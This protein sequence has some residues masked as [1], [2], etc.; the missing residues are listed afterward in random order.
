MTPSAHEWHGLRVLKINS[1]EV[2]E[3]PA[4]L[5]GD[6]WAQE[7]ELVIVPVQRLDPAFF[8][9]SSGLAGDLLQ[10]FVNYGIRLVILG[11]LSAYTASSAALRA[12]VAESNRGRAIWFLDDLDELDARLARL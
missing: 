9:L 8:D 7:A 1:G 5:I 10:K 2:L 11:D 12:F 6:A 3:R 4:D